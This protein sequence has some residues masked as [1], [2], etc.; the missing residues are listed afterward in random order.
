MK[1]GII[2][3][4]AGNSS[5]LGSP[6]QLLPYQHHTLLEHT[7]KAAKQTQFNPIVLV[8]GAYAEDILTKNTEQDINVIINE[9]WELGISSSIA[10]GV[11]K[12]HHLAPETTDIIIAVS[13]QPYISSSI[14]KALV[15]ERSTSGKKIVASHY[16]QTMGTPVLLN[17]KYFDELL[18][19]TGNTGAKP[20]LKKYPEDVATIPF[21]LGN[22]DIDTQK[23]YDNL[24]YKQ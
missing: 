15:E 16:S 9:S 3:L 12:M 22:I 4:S 10:L 14:F 8:L 18:L 23:D 19:L 5:R 1:I 7:L 21:E 24:I 2:I 13:D 17:K 11:L 6:K 20:L